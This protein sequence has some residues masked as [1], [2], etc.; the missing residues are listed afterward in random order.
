MKFNLARSVGKLPKQ[1]C[2]PHFF[3]NPAHKHNLVC[4]DVLAILVLNAVKMQ[5]IYH[6]FNIFPVAAALFFESSQTVNREI[7]SENVI[8]KQNQSRPKK[9]RITGSQFE[10]TG[11]LRP[12]F[13]TNPLPIV[14]SGQF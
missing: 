4:G 2:F 5:M 12:C 13:Q 14:P 11:A 9:R 8:F 3:Q 6:P 7:L 10:I 1:F